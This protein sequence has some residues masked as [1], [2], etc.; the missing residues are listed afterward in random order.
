MEMKIKHFATAI[1]LGIMLLLNACST[2]KKD[3]P[4]SYPVDETK[5][6]NAV[7]KVEALSKYGNLPTYRVFGKSYHVLTSS[8]NY[9]QVGVA[10]WYG[11][12]FHA[13]RT[14]S[15]ERYN[16][17][18]MTA[19]HKTLPLPTYV[20][21]TNLANG[22]KIIVKVND[23]GPFEA[24]RI[25]DLSY[26]AAKKLGML[27]HG[28]AMVDVKAIDPLHYDRNSVEP[29]HHTV[30]S[31]VYHN[32]EVIIAENSVSEAPVETI[33]P[34]TSAKHLHA[35]KTA[36]M[37]KLTKKTHLTSA[38]KSAHKEMVYLQIGSFKN[39]INAEQLKRKLTALVSSP[40]RIVHLAKANSLYQ[41]Q[42]GPF[43]DITTA[44][45]MTK[46]LRSASLSRN[47]RMQFHTE[48]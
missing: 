45:L 33:Q 25:I 9:D 16:M 12:A 14:S 3:G 10:S 19:A 39:K 13:Q 2:V 28:T 8:K 1:V 37:A 41:V 7:P 47:Q 5:I 43:K 48:V 40:I 30:P 23:R 11:T 32:P 31:S 44:K 20:Q 6:P 29:I 35:T 4:P 17:L 38:K 46:R 21:V 42:V 18:A 34:T 15:G 24:N 26:V 22:R 36:K 27:G